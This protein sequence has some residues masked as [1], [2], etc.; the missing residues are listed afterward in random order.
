MPRNVEHWVLENIPEDSGFYTEDDFAEK[1]P[2]EWQRFR[3]KAM[4]E[5]RCSRAK[6]SKAF[7]AA[8][9]K[10]RPGTAHVVTRCLTSRQAAGLA[11]RVLA[12]Q[13]EEEEFIRGRGARVRTVFLRHPQGGPAAAAE[14]LGKRLVKQAIEKSR[15]AL[16]ILIRGNCR[17]VCLARHRPRQIFCTIYHPG[18]ECQAEWHEDADNSFGTAIVLLQGCRSDKIM[19][20]VGM[21]L[22]EVSHAPEPGQA[23]IMSKDLGFHSVPP[24]T[25]ANGS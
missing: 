22:F 3:R 1:N 17:R 13:S 12:Y 18:D 24:F 8:R 9:H 10:R 5:C 2:T 20:R 6:L 4:A 15:D 7:A 11:K 19:L 21:P 14:L 16:S 25:T 23:L